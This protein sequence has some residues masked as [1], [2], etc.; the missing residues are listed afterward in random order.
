MWLPKGSGLFTSPPSTNI[1]KK[2]WDYICSRTPR[3]PAALQA[4]MWDKLCCWVTLG[5]GAELLTGFIYR[6]IINPEE[7]ST[8][9]AVLPR[10]AQ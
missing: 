4:A 5:Q 3:N 8:H 6:D 1:T 7:L 2:Q 9:G 10:L